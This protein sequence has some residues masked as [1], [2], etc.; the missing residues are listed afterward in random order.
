MAKINVVGEL[1]LPNPAADG[2]TEAIQIM[3]NIVWRQECPNFP[4]DL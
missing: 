2:F 1:F 3:H 4:L